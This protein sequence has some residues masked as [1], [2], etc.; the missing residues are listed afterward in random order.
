MQFE[1]ESVQLFQSLPTSPSLPFLCLHSL[2]FL[3]SHNHSLPMSHPS[4]FP[5]AATKHPSLIQLRN[6]RS[7][8]HSP[9]RV[10]GRTTKTISTYLEP[11]KGIWQQGF[12]SSRAVNIFQKFAIF[13]Q[14]TRWDSAP[15]M[16]V[17]VNILNGEREN[18]K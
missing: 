6:L 3:P 13:E 17:S 16:P 4:S 2:H 11:K 9:S 12:S 15:G 8:V 1:K 18:K 10:Q 7:I 14:Y 5:F